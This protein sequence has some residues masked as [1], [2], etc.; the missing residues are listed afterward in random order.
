M[1][2]PHKCPVCEGKG[3]VKKR[4]AQVGSVLVSE[5]KKPIRFRCHGCTG[6]GIIWDH[7]FNF[8]NIPSVWSQHDQPYG[9]ITYHTNSECPGIVDPANTVFSN[10]KLAPNADG[11]LEPIV[12]LFGGFEFITDHICRRMSNPPEECDYCISQGR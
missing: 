4:L 11:V 1:S 6:T 9:D 3:E 7:T 12:P 5:P 8:I 10:P 2:I